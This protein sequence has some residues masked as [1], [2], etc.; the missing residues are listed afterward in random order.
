MD[1]RI[2]VVGIG[3]R[4]PGGR[5]PAGVWQMLARQTSEIGSAPES[6]LPFLTEHDITDPDFVRICRTGGYVEGW[7]EFDHSVFGISVRE[8][9]VMDPQ[10]RI[11]LETAFEAINDAG[12]TLDYLQQRSTG[13][14]SGYITRDNWANARRAAR[15][16]AMSNVGHAGSGLSSRISHVFGLTGP[17]TTVDTACSTGLTAVATAIENIL[18]GSC[19]IAIAAANNLV[20]DPYETLSFHRSHMMAPDS[21][22]K[23]GTTV[24]DGFVRSDGFVAVVLRPLADAIAENDRIYAVVEA[25]VTGNDGGRSGSFPTPSVEGQ[26]EVIRRALDIAGRAPED[27]DYVEAHGTG[28]T[29]GDRVELDG[30]TS[31]FGERG[32]PLPVGSVKTRIGH[33]EA[34]AGLAGFV[35]AA[36]SLYHSAVRPM[37]V[38]GELR[39]DLVNAEHGLRA[40][41]TTSLPLP[42]D[43][44]IGVN[45]FGITG[46]NSHAILAAPPRPVDTEDAALPLPLL[47]SA[48][49]DA[50]APAAVLAHRVN[51]A[52]GGRRFGDGAAPAAASP[53]LVAGLWRESPRVVFAFGGFGASWLDPAT[54]DDPLLRTHLDATYAA[55]RARLRAEERE[56]FDGGAATPAAL[57]PYATWAS[58]LAIAFTLGD[59]GVRPD[60]VL[61]HSFGDIAAA[62]VAGALDVEGAADLLVARTEAVREHSDRTRMIVITGEGVAADRDWIPEWA[63][64]A[65]VN[66][67]TCVV[68][69]CPEDGIDSIAELAAAQGHDPR[70][71]DVVFGSH[72]RFVE[73][74][75]PAFTPTAS[76]VDESRVTIAA[77]YSGNGSAAGARRTVP[78]RH[79]LDN[80]RSPVDLPGVLGRIAEDGY[81][82]IV[83]IGPKAVLAGH[84]RA[85]FGGTVIETDAAENAAF[86]RECLG[87]LFVAGV[88]LRPARLPKWSSALATALAWKL[89]PKRLR[90]IRPVGRN[91]ATPA[92][93]ANLRAET[94]TFELRGAQLRGLSGH[95]VR[96]ETVIPGTLTLGCIVRALTS[97]GAPPLS[98][99]HVDSVRFTEAVVIDEDTDYLA[100]T[101]TRTGNQLDVAFRTDP[102]AEPTPCCTATLARADAAVAPS[103]ALPLNLTP[104][105]VDEFYRECAGV[106]NLWAGPFRAMT[107]LWASVSHAYVSAEASEPLFV[108]GD[109]DPALFDAALHGL[110]AVHFGFVAGG[111]ATSPFYFD[112][113]DRITFHRHELRGR[114]RSIIAPSSSGRGFDIAILDEHD[115]VAIQCT[116]VRVRPLEHR[117]PIPALRRTWVPFADA[118]TI[119]RGEY[120]LFDLA[121]APLGP[122]VAATADPNTADPDL[123]SV[124][125]RLLARFG[126]DRE[127][128]L[129]ARALAECPT[130][131]MTDYLA[132]LGQVLARIASAAA[133]AG[134]PLGIAVADIER[135]EAGEFAAAATGFL[136]TLAGA[137]AAEFPS[138]AVAVVSTDADPLG[139]LPS[140]R[141]LSE[142]G[143]HRV[144]RA[145]DGTVLVARLTGQPSPTPPAP[146]NRSR[147]D[148]WSA[149]VR[150]DPAR[151][152]DVELV[153]SDPNQGPRGVGVRPLPRNYR[154]ARGLPD[155]LWA[156]HTAPQLVT[157]ARLGTDDQLAVRGESPRT[158][159][160]KLALD[161]ATSATYPGSARRVDIVLE[162]SVAVHVASADDAGGATFTMP[163]LNPA[164]S[165]PRALAYR[166]GPTG[167]E[168]ALLD[169]ADPAAPE[170]VTAP[171]VPRRAAL[172]VGGNGGLGTALAADL[173]ARSFD[174][175]I[176]VGTREAEVQAPFDYLRCDI[177]EASSVDVLEQRLRKAEADELFIFHLAGRLSAGPLTELERGDWLRVL[178]PKVEGTCNLV[179]LA[180]RTGARLVAYSSASSVLPSPQFAHYGAANGALEGILAS[181]ADRVRGHCIR[182][183][184]WAGAGML[185]DLDPNR[186]FTPSGV[187]ELSAEQ[188]NAF[189]WQVLDEPG[190]DFPVCYPADWAQFGNRYETIRRDAL[191]TRLRGTAPTQRAVPVNAS[192]TATV[193]EPADH[194]T[195]LESLIMETLKISDVSAVR[196]AN[197]LRTIGLDSLLAVELRT[198]IKSAFGQTV[199]IRTLLGSIT[200]AGLGDLVTGTESSTAGS[201]R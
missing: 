176:L 104:L 1:R 93:S 147:L 34:T 57:Q 127:L 151:A 193:L 129:D 38:H 140:I 108:G 100:F 135:A 84:L 121:Q 70:P 87:G 196:A 54:V 187:R 178:A 68:L 66:S 3:A 114:T 47:R 32:R 76:A 183:G 163:E 198:K 170:P 72:S 50:P 30:L 92:P 186:S 24:A 102:A 181:A 134:V 124:A 153:W 157:L 81:Q 90:P 94:T 71:L 73:P 62:C 112:G 41:V 122:I 174:D 49:V 117:S 51:H 136:F 6:R 75:I 60:A 149:E 173:L 115:R 197:H 194:V 188:G 16:D 110:A 22:C 139:E 123:E 118:A 5:G 42:E 143:E 195:P 162:E 99:L 101:V 201:S 18:L 165:W 9:E 113:L 64:V 45:S 11:A 43:A 179:D 56:L 14:I 40:Q 65:V 150:L 35:V 189:L 19:S 191:L 23:F 154:Q 79:W 184:F 77:F 95:Q 98:A 166:S 53:G 80:L 161:K 141:A 4:L 182:W 172:V 109:I 128:L 85:Q 158:A 29:V 155:V 74:A 177:T 199:P 164:G 8:A 63:D 58:Q 12:F 15:M 131:S 96:G 107:E 142:R 17:S 146:P 97:A 138:L 86:L 10:Q 192:S 130:A 144:R 88:P 137:L 180:A 185:R 169:L 13:V 159:L 78:A 168:S 119:E 36:L 200:P 126:A 61:G 111:R 156:A 105:S 7:D 132:G 46:T 89:T 67:P 39:A 148:E 190:T 20:L 116:G 145:A 167:T 91:L 44:V 2:A 175:I 52:T 83:D 120:R 21:L 33:C 28:T 55:I 133:D 37:L 27:V 125:A 171:S 103:I 82:V 48:G 31:V 25:V 160:L 152:C 69:A 59:Y 106:G 26:A